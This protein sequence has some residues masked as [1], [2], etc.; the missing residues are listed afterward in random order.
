MR[1]SFDFLFKQK[2]NSMEQ[3]V[4]LRLEIFIHLLT[5]FY[6]QYLAF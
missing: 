2:I 5:P 6:A 4:W 3:N 1:P